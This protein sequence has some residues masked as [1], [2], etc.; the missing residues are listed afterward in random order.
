M[1]V[2]IARVGGRFSP[3]T[4]EPT[5]IDTGDIASELGMLLGIPDSHLRLPGHE[6]PWIHVHPVKANRG[7]HRRHL[8]G[9][10]FLAQVLDQVDQ[11]LL[12]DR[13]GNILVLV[14][15]EPDESGDLVTLPLIVGND[16]VDVLE[17]FVHA[18]DHGVVFITA[19]LVGL[20]LLRLATGGRTEIETQRPIA[21]G[22]LDEQ[23]RFLMVGAHHV[24]EGHFRA[25]EPSIGGGGQRATAAAFVFGDP[26]L[27]VGHIVA[28]RPLAL[29]VGK[30]RELAF[31]DE[32]GEI[33]LALEINVLEPEGG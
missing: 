24:A 8:R 6:M 29:F 1:V 5:G 22:R 14:P 3:S 7:N 4:P 19:E 15:L 10:K 9:M 17:G 27:P 21:H 11:V 13:L 30:P 32:R 28:N 33:A 26:R 16:L 20:L 12:V 25:D 31:L 18:R 23:N 2:V